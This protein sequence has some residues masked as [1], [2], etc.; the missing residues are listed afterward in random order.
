MKLRTLLVASLLGTL[1]LPVVHP[2]VS[3]SPE[4]ISPFV[5]KATA[6]GEV[7]RTQALATA[8]SFVK[9]L[10]Q[11]DLAGAFA[12][13]HGLTS[14]QLEAR[15]LLTRL[16]T[17]AASA[18]YRNLSDCEE[19]LEN[20]G[21]ALSAWDRAE[22]QARSCSLKTLQ[23]AGLLAATPICP[24]GGQYRITRTMSGF[25]VCCLHDAH[26]EIGVRGNY[27]AITERGTLTF[28]GQKL[29]FGTRVAFE[30]RRWDLRVVHWQADFRTLWLELKEESSFEGGPFRTRTGVL[31]MSRQEGVWRVD[32]WLT[33]QA[34]NNLF[35]LGEWH[36][37]TP[38]AVMALCYTLRGQPGTLAPEQEQGQAHL[39]LK[40]CEGNL[41]ALAVTLEDLCL[42]S[43][44]HYPATAPLK[45][46][47]CRSRQEIPVCPAG[48]KYV[49]T[50]TSQGSYRVYCAGHAH[51]DA[52]IPANLPSVDPALGVVDA[53]TTSDTPPGKH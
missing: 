28:G 50:R 52:E 5:D 44:G 40:I 16:N 41:R 27:P 6:L 32:V 2:E 18:A 46:I 53:S 7:E 48:G 22:S 1:T 34:L 17:A 30:V 33:G 37:Q 11:H 39:L 36:K 45:T 14:P 10:Y 8:E 25:T 21:T 15:Q 3:A 38:L 20:I 19:N 49:Y 24:S 43:K 9:R 12:H 35:D 51:A 26:T 47:L 31:A 13:V 4:S 23:A 42:A 29:T